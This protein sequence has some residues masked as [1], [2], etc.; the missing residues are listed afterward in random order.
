MPESPYGE[1]HNE[2]YRVAGT[3]VA[4]DAI[5][6]RFWAGDAPESI[7]QSFPVLTLEH[8]YG[9]LAYYLRHQAHIDTYLQQ[10]EA[11][12]AARVAQLRHQNR[13]LHERLVLLKQERVPPHERE[14]PGGCQRRPG[15]SGNSQAP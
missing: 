3:R 2:V 14:V 11:E 4:L 13:A 15:Y 6:R 8:V 5:V 9:A 7:V 10:A 1:Y 12:E